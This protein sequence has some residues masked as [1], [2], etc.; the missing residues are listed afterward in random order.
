MENVNQIKKITNFKIVLL[1]MENAP[2]VN[3]VIISLKKMIKD[4]DK[5]EVLGNGAV[6]SPV[7]GIIAPV[8]LS[9]GVKTL[10]LIDQINDKVF[11]ASNCG[12]NCARWLLE[13]GRE[14]DVVINLRHL[15]DFGDGQFDIEIMN[16]GETVHNMYDLAVKAGRFV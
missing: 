10:I 4:V 14:K 9:G 16:T 13:M 6:S 7:M 1:Q 5:S 2:D 11:N 12:D 8:S 3:M 15:M